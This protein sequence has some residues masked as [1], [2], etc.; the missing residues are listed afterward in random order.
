MS[1]DQS[2]NERAAR[3]QFEAWLREVEAVAA[4][5][6]EVGVQ[7]RRTFRSRIAAA[8]PALQTRKGSDCITAWAGARGG[9]ARG[10]DPRWQKSTMTRG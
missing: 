1:K 5:L 7:T 4:E 2:S 6:V 10:K 3:Q 8:V 9:I